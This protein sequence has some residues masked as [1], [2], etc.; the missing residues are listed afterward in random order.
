MCNFY[1]II[2]QRFTF[3]AGPPVTAGVAAEFRAAGLGIDEDVA[4]AAPDAASRAGAGSS[5]G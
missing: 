4:G 1:N 3:E 5:E 2:V